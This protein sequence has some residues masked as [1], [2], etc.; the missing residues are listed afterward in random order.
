MQ[1]TPGGGTVIALTDDPTMIDV[2]E[3]E[4]LHIRMKTRSS[5]AGSAG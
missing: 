4:E 5:S 3:Y 1:Q 2:L